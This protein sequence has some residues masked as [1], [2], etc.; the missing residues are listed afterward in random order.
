MTTPG[1]SASP[2][3]VVGET[4]G[5]VNLPVTLSAP[6]DSTVTVGYATS[7]GS[8]GDNTYCE[9][10]SSIYQGQSG[11]LTFTP[12]VTTQVV[13]VPL[14]NCDIEPYDRLLHLLPDPVFEQHRLHDQQGYDPDRRHR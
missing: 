4:D 9:Y 7:T 12:G 11:T 1:I 8:G 13:R 2:D 10:A 6:G 3:V 14:L 5:Y